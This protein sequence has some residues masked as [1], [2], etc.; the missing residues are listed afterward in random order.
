MDLQLIRQ[1][2]QSKTIQERSAIL[3]SL[4]QDELRFFYRNPDLFLFDK[5][6]IPD[7][8]DWIYYL[9]RCGR[10]FGKSYAGSAWIAKKIRKGAKIIGLCG[11][12]YDDVSKIMV[13]A[14]LAWFLPTELHETPYNHQTHTISFTN[15]AKIY[16]Y[17]S[18]KEIRGPNL[19]YLW[20]DE[21]CQWADEQPEKIKT[22]FEDIARAVRVG[23][24][25]QIIITSTPKP[26]PFFFDFQDEIDKHNP[27][28]RMLVG[29]MFDNPFLPE[30]YKQQQIEK[31]GNSP[32][33]IQ[34][35]YGGLITEN[36][37]ALFRSN[38]I[39]ENRITDPLNTTR[40]HDQ[41]VRYF[42]NLV[43]NK[44]ILIKRMAISVDPS[45][46]NQSTSDETGIILLAQDFKNEVY[47]LYDL[48]DRHSPDA[49]AKVIRNLF[50]IY[51]KSFD[52][53]IVAET[54]FGKD[55]VAANIIAA[56]HLLKPFIKEITATKGKLLRAEPAAAKYQRNKIHHI[57]YFDKL[58]RQM[59]NYTGPANATYS[60]D[61][62]DALVHG[63]NELCIVPQYSNRDV[64]ILE[65]Y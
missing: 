51:A 52:I 16:C 61:R 8:T 35:L 40:D 45:G 2:F 44:E 11:P 60:P 59:L 4:N 7:T 58:E 23:T 18:E 33:G 26:H 14:I 42:F 53:C 64:S 21:I 30:K 65:N 54:N 22:R 36:P 62:M 49:W 38:W 29:S 20:C 24:Y 12:T 3:H 6:I 41:D 32:K 5:Q 39:N 9:L 34:E 10:S 17:T 15:G 25:P 55:L 19:E 13:P 56:D 63:I 43:K 31:Y 57:G 27:F 48:S 1:Q 46:S 28:Y 50:H 37:E 47:V